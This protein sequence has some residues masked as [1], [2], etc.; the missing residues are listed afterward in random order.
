M[1]RVE[2]LAQPYSY[3][4]RELAEPDWTRLP[5]WHGVAPEDWASAQWQRAHCI[6]NVK[7]LRALMGGLLEERFYHDLERDQAQRATMSM[8][9]PP[10][11][12]NTMV[13]AG[14]AHGQSW[15]E[16]FHADPIRRYML[17]VFSDRRVD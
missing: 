11:M 14:P 1:E 13:A 8:L 6:K 12:L 2:A 9:V 17:P 10:Q 3:R 4:R 5:G 15:T 7:Q 16:A